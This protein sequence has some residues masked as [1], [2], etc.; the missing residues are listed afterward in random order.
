MAASCASTG[1]ARP[2]M[3]LLVIATLPA[4]V[5]P[6]VA[7][8]VPKVT[9]LPAFKLPVALTTPPVMMLPAFKLPV[10]VINPAVPKLPTLALPET[11]A[12]VNVP[13]EVIF[14]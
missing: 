10:A 9:R 1:S 5:A 4:N 14:G 3:F 11:L 13:R 6:P 2:V 8:N 12:L 7:L